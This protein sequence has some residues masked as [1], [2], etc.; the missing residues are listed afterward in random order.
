LAG[1]NTYEEYEDKLLPYL[2]TEDPVIE[3]AGTV[4]KMRAPVV[5]FLYLGSV[6]GT[7]HLERFEQVSRR[8][9]SEID[10]ALDL[11]DAERP[12][13]SLKGATFKHSKWLRDGLATTL[14]LFAVHEEQAKLYIREGA[15]AF[16]DQL[17]KEL[18]GLNENH[19]LLASLQ[20]QLPL[21]MEAAPRPLL[22]ALEQ[23]LGGDGA[24]IRPIF[25]DT[26]DALFAE[27]PHTGLLWGLETLAWDPQYL[28]RVSLILAGLTKADDPPGKLMNRPINSLRE[29][30]LPWN[31]G[32]N[33]TLSQR[34]GVLDQIIIQEPG[35]A[36]NL[37]LMLMP[38]YHSVS[39][40]TAKPRFR[41]AGASERE[42][43]TDQLVWD[44]YS[45]A[46]DRA[47]ALAGG[48]AQRWSTL[49]ESF[50]NF[51]PT[52]LERACQLLEKLGSVS[53]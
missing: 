18:P 46:I 39:Q 33:A 48:D 21:L 53:V 24:A 13:A 31:P 41:E 22:S 10:P 6:I 23:L 3:R 37:L 51:D 45:G 14:L 11:P 5:G 47:L 50:P 32:T 49:V 8:V 43:R 38:Q 35:V 26:E 29:I 34:F 12:Y 20:H 7:Q 25:T 1:T 36:W 19:R 27:S 40:P 15:Q 17:I 42:G 28:S 4:W 30:F 2:R 44:A 16:V 52:H 9:F